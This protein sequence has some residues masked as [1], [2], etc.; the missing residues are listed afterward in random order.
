M[1]P[2]NHTCG[3]HNKP[4]TTQAVHMKTHHAYTHVVQRLLEMNNQNATSYY[5][6]WFRQVVNKS[7]VIAQETCLLW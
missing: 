2:C 7:V 3:A 6:R 1:V 4:K 5:G